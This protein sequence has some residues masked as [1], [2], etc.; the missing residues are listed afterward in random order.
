MAMAGCGADL[1]LLLRRLGFEG[2]RRNIRLLARGLDRLEALAIRHRF[3]CA[4]ERTGS[5]ALART[6]RQAREQRRRLEVYRRF[7]VDAEILGPPAL[8]HTLEAPRFVSGLHVPRTT[9]LVD[10]WRV[11]TGLRRAALAAGVVLH[12]GTPVL[13]IQEGTELRLVT[14]F[15]TVRAPAAVLATN[16]Y[17]SGLG[18]FRHRV[19]PVHVSC[20]VTEPLDAG[21]RAALG[22][23]LRQ[24]LWEEG[25]L[26][27]FLRLTPDNRLLIGGGG[28]VYRMGDRLDFPGA[29]KAYARL[30]RAIPEIFPTLHEARV[31]HRWSG[32]VGFTRDFLPSFGATG[33][34]GNIYYA[35]GYSGHG[36]A[37]SHLAAEVLC[38]LY[39][40]EQGECAEL[41]LLNRP[42]PTLL[43]EPLKWLAI[44]GVRNGLWVLDRLGL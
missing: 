19:A 27:H 4:F 40:G 36:V 26:Y 33:E 12:E 13:R 20:V 5:L 8:R 18:L 6:E 15:G 28:A 11:V 35:V 32:P 41:F 38:D 22:W 34:R 23:D 7:G 9:A 30:E 37:L 25:R 44:N 14:P 29:A 43:F 21:Q 3:D 1:D 31:T 17:S 16:A 10:P 2:A 42:L 24:S 39:A